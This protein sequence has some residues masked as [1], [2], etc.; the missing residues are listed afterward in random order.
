MI[1]CQTTEFYVAAIKVKRNGA[2]ANIKQII[3]DA[4]EFLELSFLPYFKKELIS[5]LKN[6]K[7]KE[8]NEN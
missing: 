5:A 2:K 8:Q 6:L 7:K 4:E 1:T 3:A